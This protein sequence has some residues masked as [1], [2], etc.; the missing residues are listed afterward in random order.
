L[1]KG[2]L[3][4][5]NSYNSTVIT[6]SSPQLKNISN[7]NLG[8]LLIEAKKAY[9]T[10]GKPIMDDHTYDTLE[11]ILKKKLP[12][13]R[14][15]S[16]IG[17]PN[18][19]TGLE[20]KK[21]T[22]VMLSQN[23]VTN[24]QDLVHYFELKKVSKTDGFVTQVKCDGLSVEIEYQNG[25]LVDAITRGDG[26]IGDVITQ[27]IVKMKG[28]MMS[29]PN[30]FTG[31][32]RCE[33]V[34]TKDDFKKLNSLVKGVY[35]NPRNAAS[36][37]SQ[38]LD[39]QYSE[40]CS[41]IAVDI[42]PPPSTENDKIKLLKSLNFSPVD[43][44]LCQSF[45]EIE[46]LYQQHLKKR[47]DFAHD[48]DG[49]VVKIN[50]QEI[51]QSLGQKNGRPKY[52]VAYKF[53]A[54]T[55]T[56]T[57][58][59]IVWQVGPMG[60][61]TPVAQI[62]PVELSGAIIT[63]ASL[64]NYDLV[65]KM[66]LN[67]G[68]IV[69]I[70]RRGDVIPHVESVTTKINSGHVAI[71]THCPTCQT[72]LI[73]E[74]KALHCPN[75]QN[76]LSQIIGS[77]NL[78][79]QTLNILGLSDKTISKL[80]NAGRLKT[81]GD[82]FKLTV[83][84]IKDLDNLGEKSAKNIIFQIQSKKTLTLKQIF[85][86][87]I[88]PHFSGARILQL[89]TAGFDT[90]EKLLNITISD[91]L[92]IKGFKETLAQKI[93]NGISLRKEWISSILSNVNLKFVIRN[94]KFENLVFSITGTLSLPRQQLIDQIESNGGKFVSA[95]SSNT[96]YLIANSPSNS[97]KYLTAQKLNI[98]IITENDFQELLRGR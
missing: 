73:K 27:N 61:I 65:T 82:F 3:E 88:I 67:V 26:H 59:N 12:H 70:S 6:L 30:H 52:Q 98:K 33:I 28:M 86:A 62:E 36:G 15:F 37:I 48:I 60:A 11:E 42:L 85:D 35:S 50:N 4:G 66:D 79:C 97:D 45:E 14:L 9:Y 7:E 75:S 54:D 29:L 68:D 41:L 51:A 63:F 57:V 5:L 91:L 94:L 76:C 53:P 43:S 81:P 8:E 18:F 80:F 46:T 69:K 16:K 23:K 49:L 71:P 22:F 87:S 34:V 25:K 10:G 92:Q 83:Y 64:G 56:S 47:F 58:K 20:K 31:S 24:F 38:R 19:D 55:D 1:S 93:V 74:D 17:T 72:L 95:V 39:S 78:F 13:H 44:H 2:D 40:Y 32:I 90:P 89:I 77:L 96:N 84:D 21:H